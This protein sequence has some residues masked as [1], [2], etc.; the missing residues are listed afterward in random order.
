MNDVVT[1]TPAVYDR[2]RQLARSYMRGERPGHSLRPTELVH[3]VFLRMIELNQIEWQDQRH[4]CA[5]AATQMRRVLVEYARRRNAEKRGGGLTRITLD[6]AAASTRVPAVDPLELDEA[7]VR[8]DS[9]SQRQRRVAEM[10]LFAGMTLAEIADV[11]G[12]SERTARR[13]WRAARA[14]LSRELSRS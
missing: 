8:L 3:E 10:R 4:F 2:L 1:L 13:E 9:R 14:W 12:T 5:L 6:E 7:L 11:L